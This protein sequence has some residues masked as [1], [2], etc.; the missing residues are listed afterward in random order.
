MNKQIKTLSQM[1]DS[2]LLFE[3]QLPPFGYFFIFLVTVFLAGVLLWS[4]KAPKYR[5]Q[6]NKK[7]SERGN[8]DQL[9]FQLCHVRLFRGNW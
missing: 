9:W 3:K 7:I 6:K 4:I 1:R 8:S 5:Y 2:R